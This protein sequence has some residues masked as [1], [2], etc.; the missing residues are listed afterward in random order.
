MTKLTRLLAVMTAGVPLAIVGGAHPAAAAPLCEGEVATIVGTPGDDVIL[1][2]QLPQGQ[3]IVGLGGNDSILGSEQG[4]TICGGDGNDQIWAGAGSDWL[5]G[6]P[7]DDRLLAGIDLDV[8][9][10]GA[11][12]NGVNVDLTTGTASGEGS[13]VIDGAEVLVGSELG[14]TLTGG[15]DT[16]YLGGHGGDDR[17]QGGPASELLEGGPGND[18]VDGRGGADTVTGDVGNDALFGGPGLNQL[19]GGAGNDSLLPGPEPFRV[20]GGAGVDTVY[21]TEFAAG[22]VVNLQTSTIGGFGFITETENV[23]G[24]PFADVLRGDAA[25]NRLTGGN[26]PDVIE[27]ASGPDRLEGGGG[28]DRITGGAGVTGR[29][30]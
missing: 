13:D 24:T 17:I 2:N 23:L 10:Y 30:R 14:D 29:W 16:I 28:S 8:V 11:A 18:V 19:Q 1:A 9:A 5:A 6:G 22:L 25:A 27:G 12:T 21:F 3:V 20:L 26:G 4:D 7:G 15:A